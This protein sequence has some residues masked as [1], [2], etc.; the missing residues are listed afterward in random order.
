VRA[1]KAC[2]LGCQIDGVL[3]LGRQSPLPLMSVSHGRMT[4]FAEFYG[5]SKVRF[6]LENDLRGGRVATASCAS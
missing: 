2:D 5:F 6:V 4:A 1:T 3:R